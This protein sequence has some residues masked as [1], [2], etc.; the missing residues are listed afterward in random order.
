MNT[1]LLRQAVS[2]THDLVAAQAARDSA[3]VVRVMRER[4][5]VLEQLVRSLDDSDI[6]MSTRGYKIVGGLVTAADL[7]RA[8][9]E[10][11]PERLFEA[12]HLTNCL[13]Q[14]PEFAEA[15]DHAAA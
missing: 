15:L 5:T 12:E 4:A 1:Q 6:W 3:G 14:Y 13:I 7:G 11:S 2:L 9:N 8:L 10:V